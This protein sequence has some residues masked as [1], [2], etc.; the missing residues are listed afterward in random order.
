MS[1]VLK[2]FFQNN[3][4]ISYFSEILSQAIK[5]ETSSEEPHKKSPHKIILE[6]GKSVIQQN[7]RLPCNFCGKIFDGQ[8]KLK[9]H[10]QSHTGI[11]GKYLFNLRK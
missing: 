9:R 6:V 10:M 8:Y 2:P 5:M 7:N 1:L 11:K 4:S 3:G